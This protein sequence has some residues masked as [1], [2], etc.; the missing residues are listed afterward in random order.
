MIPCTIA[1]QAS[2]SITNS[3]SLLKLMSI[4][5]VMLYKHLILCSP[6]LLQPSIF[7]SIRIFSNKSVLYIRWPKFWSFSF[8]TSPSNEHSG[9]IC[10]R[11]NLL[12]LLAVQG[13]LMSLLQHHSSKTSILQ[14]SALSF[15]P[16]LSFSSF[17]FIKR[18]FSS[19]LF[20][21]IRVVSSAYLRLLIFLLAILILACASSSPVFH[22]MYSAYK[23][24][25]G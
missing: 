4:E 19:S 11:T 12:D 25:A 9:L 17:T 15:K 22:M 20:S 8:S 13:T 14:H 23:L 6:L 5:S 10:F 21:A 7:P 16:S 2:L 1:C 18:L 24:K 3:Q